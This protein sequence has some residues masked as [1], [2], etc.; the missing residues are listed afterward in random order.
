MVELQADA[1][2]GRHELC[3]KVFPVLTHICFPMKQIC[4]PDSI[5]DSNFS[6]HDALVTDGNDSIGSLQG[7][8]PQRA[9][10]DL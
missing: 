10:A 2:L 5:A 8:G 3:E 1:I 6:S 7:A 9:H 4:L